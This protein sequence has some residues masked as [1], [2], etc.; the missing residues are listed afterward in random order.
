MG[1]RYTG[2]LSSSLVHW[3]TLAGVGNPCGES[4]K[5][6]GIFP[7]PILVG[8]PN[9][10]VDFPFGHLVL[11]QAKEKWGN[12]DTRALRPFSKAS[13]LPEKIP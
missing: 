10:I 2:G 4:N 7:A 5:T 11:L 6:S 13:K 9:G 3:G 12:G 8:I 1:R